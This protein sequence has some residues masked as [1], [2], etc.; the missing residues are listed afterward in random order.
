M[1]STL[2]CGVFGDKAF[3]EVIIKMRLLGYFPIHSD[4]YLYE[5]IWTQRNIRDVHT[6]RKDNVRTQ[7][8]S[9]QH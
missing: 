1:P 8:V 4:W 2:E 7:Q 6:Q 3:K 9:F 5:K